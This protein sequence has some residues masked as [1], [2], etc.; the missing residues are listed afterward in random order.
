MSPQETIEH[1]LVAELE[2]SAH[3]TRVV[4]TEDGIDVLHALRPDVGELLDLGRGVLDL[5]VGHLQAELLHSRL[6][7][8]PA[9]QPVAA[10]GAGS[11][12]PRNYAPTSTFSNDIHQQR[13]DDLGTTEAEKE[14]AP[15][16][17]VARETKIFRLEDLIGRG[18][19]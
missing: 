3:N 6:D 14:N 2:L 11:A 17:D 5:V 4:H 15:N 1:L 7:R 12:D 10:S 16:G 9:R 8:V 19:V 18:V 13:R